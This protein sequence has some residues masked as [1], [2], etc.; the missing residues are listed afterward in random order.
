MIELL[1]SGCLIEPTASL[2]WYLSWDMGGTPWQGHARLRRLDEWRQQSFERLAAEFWLPELAPGAQATLHAASQG[3]FKLLGLLDLSGP[4][5]YWGAVVSQGA[6]NLRLMHATGIP[7]VCGNDAGAVPAVEAMVG[8][9]LEMLAFCLNEPG[10]PPRFSGAEALRTATL[11]S[12]RALG[13]EDSFGS[14]TPGKVADLVILDGDPFSD[15]RRIGSPAAAV[16]LGGRLVV[17]A[18]GLE[19]QSA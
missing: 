16:F 12:A 10:E 2:A 19:K 13:L 9:E 7:V 6:D 1:D 3:K 4:F 17:N 11:Y 8:H 14:I 18:G 5:R 15:P